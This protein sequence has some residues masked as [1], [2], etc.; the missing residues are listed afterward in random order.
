MSNTVNEAWP[1]ANPPSLDE[2][3]AFAESLKGADVRAAAER[4]SGR[5]RRTPVLRAREIDEDANITTDVGRRLANTSVGVQMLVQTAVR[6]P[7]ASDVH[8]GLDHLTQDRRIPRR[9]TDRGN[10]LDST[11]IWYFL[12]TEH[13]Q[14]RNTLSQPTCQRRA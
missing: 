12:I 2:A 4:I 11:C 7:D 13:M 6:Q 3:V 1:A 14:L 10:D 9:W 8:A 5:V